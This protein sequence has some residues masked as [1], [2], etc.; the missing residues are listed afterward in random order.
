MN[1]DPIC[2]LT[3][4]QIELL[5]TCLVENTVNDKELAA[6]LFRSVHTIHAEF[7][8]ILDALDVHSRFAAVM[9]ALHRGW[10]SLGHGPKE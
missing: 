1:D 5:Q 6:I 3:P 8:K 4:R 7:A 9:T 2:P 10:I